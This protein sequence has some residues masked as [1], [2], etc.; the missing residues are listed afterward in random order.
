MVQ[1]ISDHPVGSQHGSWGTRVAHWAGCV[2]VCVWGGGLCN[3]HAIA[4][5]GLSKNSY[6]GHAPDMSH[7]A[8]AAYACMPP[9]PT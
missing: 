4:E 8:Y 2:G 1:D 7:C 3:I 5:H 6:S 9:H